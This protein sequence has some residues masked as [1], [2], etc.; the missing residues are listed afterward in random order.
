MKNEWA[1]EI[2]TFL[3]Q[4]SWRLWLLAGLAF[5]VYSPAIRGGFIWD[6]DAYVTSNMALRS[7]RGLWEIWFHPQ[8]L[9]QYYPMTFTSLWINYH[10]GGLDPL[11]YHV[12]NVLLHALNSLFVWRLLERLKVPGAWFACLLFLLHPVNV[13]SVAWITERKNVLSGFFYLSAFLSYLRFKEEKTGLGH[14]YFIS[15]VLFLGAILSKTV[16]GTFPAAVLLVLWWKEARFPWKDLARLVPFFA[17]TAVLGAITMA[18]ESGHITSIATNEWGFTLADRFLIAGRALWFYLGKLLW[19]HP[20]TLMFIYPRWT[21]D[22]L[23]LWQWFFPLSFAFLLALS[24]IFRS[25]WGRGLFTG[26]ALFF[27]TL[28]P[29][30]GFR[31]FFPMRFSFVADHFQYL[32]TIG[33]IACA[34]ATAQTA[35]GKHPQARKVL[36][37]VLLLILGAFSWKQCGIY[38]N[39]ETLWRDTL[40]KN[41]GAWM[42]HNNLGVELLQ[43]QKLEE[44]TK[45]FK[46]GIR[47][48][49][50]FADPYNNLGGLLAAQGQPK[51]AISF[52][53]KAILFQ[54]NDAS[55]K[56][57]YGLTLSELGRVDEAI[58]SYLKAIKIN[59]SNV[60]AHFNLGN[61]F[62][63]KGELEKSA[64]WYRETIALDPG[65]IEAYVNL[66]LVLSKLDRADETLALYTKALELDPNHAMAHNNLANL[67][68]SKGRLAEAEHHYQEAIRIDPNFILF[69]NNFAS[70]LSNQG[71]IDEAIEIDNEILRRDPKNPKAQQDLRRLAFGFMSEKSRPK[72]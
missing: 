8:Q 44:A 9:V 71:R 22:P 7:L 28:F 61:A 46:E 39:L 29:A 14:W 1:E 25:R 26:L 23:A 16:T 58:L 50:D 65:Y 12:V 32:A 10:L 66:G 69:R 53:E 49:P 57:N 40:S 20:S 3:K 43:A 36:G 19:P 4:I 54:P 38:R 34:V 30:L 5:L 35:L 15:L 56:V 67:L 62:L 41:P 11:G 47:L 45:H 55:F 42:A 70:F 37:I 31:D 63:K 33:P 6:D 60:D 17:L 48:K 51:E 21:I 59:P 52:Y 18:F 72:K 64:R 2:G 68:G 27:V 13:E 24:W